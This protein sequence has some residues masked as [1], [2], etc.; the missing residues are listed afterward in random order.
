MKLC[1]CGILTGQ[2]ENTSLKIVLEDHSINCLDSH[3]LLLLHWKRIVRSTHRTSLSTA[4]CQDTDLQWCEYWPGSR[5]SLWLP[6]GKG[7][8][9][10]ACHLLA[11]ET[12]CSATIAGRWRGE[13]AWKQKKT[14]DINLCPSCSITCSHFM[15]G[16]CLFEGWTMVCWT[17]PSLFMTITHPW[18]VVLIYVGFGFCWPEPRFM[19]CFPW[20]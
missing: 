14:S 20:G 4:F 9:C 3:Y 19:G 11:C 10:L 8:V 15:H 17:P 7:H 12:G 1:K 6:L 18:S 13:P 16:S 2:C 5:T